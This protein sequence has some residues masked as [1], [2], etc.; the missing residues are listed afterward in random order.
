MTAIY[1]LSGVKWILLRIEFL[2][3]TDVSGEESESSLMSV[4][5]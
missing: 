2:I 5:L 1:F 3:F 4:N